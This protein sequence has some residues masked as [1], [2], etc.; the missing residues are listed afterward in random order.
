M[1]KQNFSNANLFLIFEASSVYFEQLETSP[2]YYVIID[3]CNMIVLD[4]LEPLLSM[5][6]FYCYYSIF[7]INLDHYIK[8]Y[9]DKISKVAP[10]SLILGIELRILLK[11]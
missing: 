7:Q 10:C 2:R 6:Y 8:S 9:T 4:P 1:S 5:S 11:S 3:W